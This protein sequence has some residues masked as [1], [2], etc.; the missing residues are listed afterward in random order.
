M[1]MVLSGTDVGSRVGAIEEYLRAK[2]LPR[3]L[4]PDL[5]ESLMRFALADSVAWPLF[6]DLCDSSEPDL[7]LE[8][9]LATGL[10]ERAGGSDGFAFTIPTAVRQ[11]LRDQYLSGAADDA[12][13]FHV[14][15]ATWFATHNCESHVSLAFHHAVAGLDWELAD[16]LWSENVV[17]MI[18]ESPSMFF[19]TLEALP[20]EV[21]ATRPSMQVFR[22]IVHVARADTDATDRRAT[23]LAF[24]ESCSRLLNS[25]WETMSSSELLIVAT[26]YMIQLRLLGRLGA[27]A[28]IGDRVNDRA[29]ALTASPS[30]PNSKVAW[31]YLH[32]GLTFSLL[33]GAASA[34][35]CY[36]RAWDHGTGAGVDFVQSQAAAN[37]SFT[38]GMSGDTALAD[39][40]LTRH[41][42]FDT[43]RWPG[44]YLVGLGGH[45]AAGF[46]ALDRLDDS[47]VRAELAR[48]GDGSAPFELWPFIAYLYAQHALHANNVGGALLHLDR[49][50][51]TYGE[52]ATRG[53]AAALLCRARVDLLIADG[54]G[55]KAKR[56][57]ESFGARS[58]LNRLPAA[59]LRLL[60]GQ[61]EASVHLDPLTWDPGT[62][63]RDRLE[64]LLLGSVAASARADFRDAER[65]ANQAM[66]LYEESR[67]L[68]PFATITSEARAR[69]FE[70]AERE[71]EP[72][73]A[74][75]LA[76]QVA[77]YPDQLFFINLSEHEQAVL[78][79][80]ARS[81]SRQTI[82][83]SLF[84][85]I[86]TVKSQLASIH[87]KI[88]STT[89]A[90]TL[91]K[92]R[93]HGLLP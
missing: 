18:Q 83:D 33:N 91:A 77:V 50:Q 58:Q 84:V 61:D 31:F 21:L 86:N 75:T 46:V 12:R 80:L 57:V 88:G 3:N 39:E 14:R 30:V 79:A 78:E 92:A 27:A 32:R 60:G 82:A 72:A 11:M 59:R 71:V 43:S 2:V 7:L 90:E 19:D 23:A 51:A 73:D 10:T 26:G 87:K 6:R 15:L 13:A 1:R 56:L 25:H 69:L 37:L 66:D 54:W 62:S 52:S 85:S 40:W 35:Y 64:M 38:H 17:T 5:T 89:R 16:R 74:A 42:S 4:D 20:A 67:I 81:G 22:D 34:I 28:A 24:G 47:A 36:T 55:E 65:F 45:L 9:L 76:R 70:L 48:L 63:T 8:R 41:R 68:R 53:A 93:E 29:S 49:L 44:N